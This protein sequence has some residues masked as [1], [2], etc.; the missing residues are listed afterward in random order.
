LPQILFNRVTI[1]FATGS[2]KARANSY[3]TVTGI[4]R[5][6]HA[7]FFIAALI[8]S[9]AMESRTAEVVPPK[10]DRYFND[11]AGVV[12]KEAAYHLN[13]ELA[14]FEPLTSNR[15]KDRIDSR[16][17]SAFL[18]AALKVRLDDKGHGQTVPEEQRPDGASAETPTKPTT[19]TA[20]HRQEQEPDTPA[21]MIPDPTG[22]PKPVPDKDHRGGAWFFTIL[23]FIIFVI[24]L[25]FVILRRGR[26]P[27]QPRH[28]DES[29]K[30][31]LYPLRIA[32]KFKS[33]GGKP[34]QQLDGWQASLKG[35][36]KQLAPLRVF[37][38]FESLNSKRL[39]EL[40][41]RARRIDPDYEPAEFWAWYQVETPAGVNADELVKP[42]RKLDNVE[43]AYVMRPSPPPVRPEDDPRNLKQVYQGA[44]P[45]GIDARY[46]WGFAGG[47]G[48]GI[49]FVDLEQGWNLNHKDLPKITIISGKNYFEY[50]HGTSVL[51]EVLMVDN[52]IGGVGIA[53]S[54]KGRVISQW[55]TASSYN[56][57]DAILHAYDNMS[58]GD[59]LLLEAQEIDPVG[60]SDL[61]PVEIA[62]ATYEAI[63]TAT[64]AGIVV[65]EAGGN[66]GHDLD[67]YINESGV[68]I[69]DRSSAG[70]REDSG[71]IMVGAGSS[72]HPHTKLPKSNHGNR[73][74]CYAWGK[75]I[76]TTTT[77]DAGKSNTM[78]TTVFGGTSGASP[79]VA[80]AALIVQGIAQWSLGR[81]FSP[82]ELRDLLTTNG[83]P[84]ATPATDRIG[85]MPDLRAI[86]TN[87]HNKLKPIPIPTPGPP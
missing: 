87:N 62:D 18:I 22:T 55:R 39:S 41:D 15:L 63:R 73:I 27:E 26:S 84:S 10:P 38:L 24:A 48:A 17:D 53:P 16:H 70:F 14:Q 44:A 66:G 49:G 47:D 36:A 83:T 60:G 69:F 50:P 34:A 33:G 7:A 68:K 32:I 64:A 78:Y 42:L 52:T 6:K 40:V 9:L 23:F 85:V 71:A 86:I 21:R 45:N 56:T 58:F 11:S 2:Q 29:Y 46:A 30:P 82:R 51:G 20:V 54:A 65:V 79:I 67:A 80:G 4:F 74:D 77:S 3:I 37:P 5:T 28:P 59:V 12:S 19:V 75:N 43:T 57:A 25:I 8:M 1:P 72:N 13:Q 76:D 81:R 35:S 61:W 31:P